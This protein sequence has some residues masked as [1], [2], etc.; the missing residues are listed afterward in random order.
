MPFKSAI[1]AIKPDLISAGCSG[2]R[3]K[4]PLATSTSTLTATITQASP[5]ITAFST[6]TET[7]TTQTTTTVTVTLPGA[8][9]ASCNGAVCGTFRSCSNTVGDCS[10]CTAAESAG[11][12]AQ[13]ASCSGPARCT[14]SSDYAGAQ[15]CA[16][17]TCCGAQ[18]ICLDLKCD[19][20]ARKL[21]KYR[22]QSSEKKT[23]RNDGSNTIGGVVA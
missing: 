10:C 21:I 4:I 14:T 18:G 8:P 7:T 11:F 20:P 23:S 19:N 13:D 1:A 6:V 22:R 17:N 3:T 9:D 12:Y 15:I 16:V 5:T 2:I